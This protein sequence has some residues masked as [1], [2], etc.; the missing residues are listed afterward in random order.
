[1]GE[2][3]TTNSNTALVERKAGHLQL[4]AN[5]DLAS[6]GDPADPPS[7][8]DLREMDIKG[9]ASRWRIWLSFVLAVLLP[10]GIVG[11]FL[12]EEA[13]ERFSSEFRIAIR[14][15]DIS[16]P[17]GAE[18]L[19]GLAGFGAPV[20]NESYATVQFLESRAIVDALDRDET[21]T[22]DE[23]F[24]DPGIDILSSIEPQA[25][26]ETRLEHWKRFVSPRFEP[27]SNTVI[28]RVTTFSP[29]HTLA[30][31]ELLLSETGAFVNAFSQLAR[32]DALSFARQELA[33]A[34]NRMHEA[35]LTL[36]EFQ[37]RERMLD[38]RETAASTQ[39]LV[40]SLNEQLV[41]QRLTLAEQSATL[42]GDGIIVQR[43]RGRISRL[44]EQIEA[45][46]DVATGKPDQKLEDTRPLAHLLREFTR[47]S[48]DASFAERAYLSALTSLEAARIEADRQK[49]F[50]ATI[51]P[52]G[53]PERA[54]YPRPFNGMLICFGLAFS[55]WLIGLIG[56]HTI[57]EH[58]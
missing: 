49:M 53:L 41:Q 9:N 38:P 12:T 11:W 56:Y 40:Y 29:E 57:R 37:Q 25:P 23:I 18:G 36:T 42:P 3:D 35:R 14:S 58:S 20:S 32:E 1:M 27:A 13:S 45:I 7:V 39:G 4:A 46:E 54:S 22:Y 15:L 19:L 44:E 8:S 47:L 16:R 5:R 6:V 48:N 10:C 33:A 55:V 17:T 2:T 34:E 31:G 21:I 52:P 43:T 24:A 50:L 51:V 26:I 28:V 30:L